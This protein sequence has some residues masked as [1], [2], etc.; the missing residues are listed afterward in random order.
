MNATFPA[1]RLLVITMI[2]VLGSVWGLPPTAAQAQQPTPSDDEVNAIASQL[3]C[4]VCENVPLDV[5]ATQ[6]CAQWRE[7]IRQKLAAGWT[8]E[9]IQ[10]YFLEQY[11]DQVVGAPPPRGLNLLA[12]LLPPL[13]FLLGGWLVLRR[14][15]RRQPPLQAIPTVSAEALARFEAE[16]RQRQQTTAPEEDE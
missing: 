8:P 12:Y 1:L 13:A 5:C 2:V 14:F 4:P 3:Y 15:T 16:L 9:Q 7:L 6:A 11:G 10:T